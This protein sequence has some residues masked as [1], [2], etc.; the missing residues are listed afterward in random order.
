MKSL[1]KEI[2]LKF[3][4]IEES[5]D[6]VDREDDDID[7]DGDT[8]SSD[9]YLHHRRKVRKKSILQDEEELDEMSATGGVAGYNIPAA[10]AKPGKWRNKSKTYESVNTPPNWK[11][12]VYQAPEDEEEEYTD[13]FPFAEDEK[14][15]QHRNYKYP[16]M[17][18]TN[19]SGLSKR[20]D[21]TKNVAKTS[22]AEKMDAKYE[23]L[24][25]S[26]RA[27]A[28]GDKKTTPE[29]KIKHTIKEVA[30]KLQEIEQTVNYASKLK[31][32]SGIARNGYGSSVETA[33]N[34]IS[35]RL[36]KISERVRALGE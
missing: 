19:T 29:Q 22:V 4:E 8:D 13:K 20:K 7:N 26:Y 31:T 15:W 1:L 18:L 35:E 24:I 2:E 17:D 11:M 9:E 16:S 36:I 6:P 21:K 33:L 10:F 32:E 34:K 25:E 14:I 23:K 27:Y 12:G 30:K 3:I 28:T 5:L